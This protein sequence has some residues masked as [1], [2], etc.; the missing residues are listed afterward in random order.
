LLKLESDLVCAPCC[1]GKMIA[2]FHSPVNTVMTEH[3]GQLLHM[4]I[5]GPSRVRSM[6]GKWY[7]L[8]IVD[9]YYRYSWV[10]FLE[11]KDQVFEHFQL[12]ALRLNNEY[13]NCLKAIH[14][15]NETEFRNVSFDEFCLEHG[16]D[17]QFS[18]PRV[19]QQNGVVKQKNRTLVEMA[20]TMLD[21]HE[22]L[23]RFWADAISTACYISNRIF[24]RSILLLT[25]FE[26]RFGRKPSVSQ[27]RPFGCKCFVLKHENLDKFESRSFDAIL[28]RYTPHVRS[29]R[30]YNFKTN[31]VVESCDVTFDETAPYPRS[32][33][34]CAG[35]KEM[36]ESIFVYERLQGVDGDEDEPLL[37]STS[38]PE[39][40]PAFTL[41]AE[42]PQATTSS[43]TAVEVSQVEGE[44]VSKAGAPS[45]IQKRHPPQQI[46]DNLNERVTRS[47]RSAHLSCFSNTLFV[48]LF[49]P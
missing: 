2:T 32:V 16:N 44:I 45:H 41:E 34:K 17:Q 7:V 15:D 38:S 14:S 24:L 5:V 25:P 4:D 49:E 26:V 6:G 29:Y 3:P 9:D 35:D 20:R 33:F 31:T 46:I 10:F 8:I 11:S 19:P 27:F 48:A 40:V 36:E 43:T 21:E 37:P 23:R 42:A 47:S 18:A 39:H 30:V 12:L 28:L 13:L 22:T 1:H